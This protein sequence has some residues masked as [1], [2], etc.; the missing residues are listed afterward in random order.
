MLTSTD[1]SIEEVAATQVN[2]VAERLTVL[3]NDGREISVPIQ[4]IPWLHWLANATPEQQAS[5]T[6]EPQGFAIY[7]EA[8]DDGIEIR[9]LLGTQMLM[10]R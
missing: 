7:W 1:E 9:H 3:L 6:I 4:E 8:L 10:H 5:W 2:F